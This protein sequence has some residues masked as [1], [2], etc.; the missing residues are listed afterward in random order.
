[1][2]VRLDFSPD[3]GAKIAIIFERAKKSVE[4]KL[5]SLRCQIL[6]PI[7]YLNKVIIQYYRMYHKLDFL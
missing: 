6:E 1:M 2:L 4:K 5:A 3:S 7:T